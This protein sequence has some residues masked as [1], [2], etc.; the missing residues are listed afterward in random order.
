MPTVKPKTPAAELRELLKQWLPKHYAV[1]VA[2]DLKG[3]FQASYIRHVRHK[4][5]KNARI[6]LALVKCARKNRDLARRILQLGK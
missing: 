3:E 5:K 4:R 6:T 2:K 1:E